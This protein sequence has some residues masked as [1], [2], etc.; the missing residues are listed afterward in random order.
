MN[1]LLS[2]H[3][4]YKMPSGLITVDL[5]GRITG[6]NPASER[7]FEG[8]LTPRCLLRDLVRESG[9][10]Q[11]M[12]DRCLDAG[13]VF[14]RV[15]FCELLDRFLFFFEEPG[16]VKNILK[17]DFDLRGLGDK[18]CRGA[19]FQNFSVSSLL[20]GNRVQHDHGE[21]LHEALGRGDAA[22]LRD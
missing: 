2:K 21:A 11:E 19:V 22:R 6:H 10:L 5:E 1:V 16:P 8:T 18:K 7:I 12:L 3:V 9:A 20:S 13:D 14:S 15:G 17:D 4:T